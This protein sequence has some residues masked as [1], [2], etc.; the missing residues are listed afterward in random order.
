MM[1]IIKNW[2][3]YYLPTATLFPKTIKQDLS[4]FSRDIEMAKFMSKYPLSWPYGPR[5]ATGIELV[6]T[7]Q[8]VSDNADKIGLTNI[9]LL[10][11]HGTNDDATKSS[12]SL[13]MIEKVSS[14]Q[15]NKDATI[16]L[17][18]GGVHGLMVDIC[19]DKC[20]NMIVEWLQKHEKK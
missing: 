16:K 18:D 7:T 14:T 1:Y 19:R 5:P 17:L 12:M 6:K 4:R 2:I 11:L 9:P 20:L 10:I 13:K 15:N 8:Y 3:A